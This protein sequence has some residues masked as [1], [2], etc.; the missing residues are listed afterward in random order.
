MIKDIKYSGHTA[1]PSDYECPDGS[2][3]LSLNLIP[4]DGTMRP[5]FPQFM[6]LRM[7]DGERALFIHKPDGARNLLSIRDCAEGSSLYWCPIGNGQ[8]DTSD[9]EYIENVTSTINGVTSVG[10][11]VMIATSDGIRYYIWREHSYMSLGNRP[12]FV[13]IEF[14]CQKAKTGLENRT[15]GYDKELFSGSSNRAPSKEDV[16]KLSTAI[17]GAL[18]SSAA[19]SA[20]KKGCF[21]Q[22][23]FVRYAFRLFD[24][25]YAWHSA[26]VLMLPVAI[27]PI[28]RLGQVRKDDE[29]VIDLSGNGRFVLMGRILPFD[30]ET[31]AKWKDIVSAVEIFV[32]AP[33]YT[34]D[35]AGEIENYRTV[36]FP[37]YIKSNN[38]AFFRGSYPA[39]TP[40]RYE[41]DMEDGI[42]E[43]GEGGEIGRTGIRPISE[44]AAK[45][46]DDYHILTGS[47]ANVL[48][49]PYYKDEDFGR[50]GQPTFL[51]RFFDLSGNGGGNVYEIPVM[52]KFLE[53]VRGCNL[54]YK[55]SEIQFDDIVLS[56]DFV[57]VKPYDN[58]LSSLVAR[59]TLPDDN[60]SHSLLIPTAVS[61]YNA[62][63]NMANMRI[64]PPAPLP[65]RTCIPANSN[66]VG[67]EGKPSLVKVTIW[68]MTQGVKLY[69][70]NGSDCESQRIFN[71]AK[72][73]PRYIFH[74]D[75]TAY[76]MK[77]EIDGGP[78]HIIPLKPHD[79]LN[80]AYF[81]SSHALLSPESVSDESL[82]N[83]SY[84]AESKIHSSEANNPFYIP[85]TGVTTVGNGAVLGLS[86]ATKALSQGQFGQFP[87]YAFTTEGV[88][89]MEVSSTGAFTARQPVTRDVCVSPQS[90]TQTDDSVLFATRRGVMMLSGSV[91]TSITDIIGTETPFRFDSLPSS[92]KLMELSGFTAGETSLLPFGEFLKD[93][94][95]VYDYANQR[96]HLF[97]PACDYGYVFSLKPKGWGMACCDTAYA[98]NSYPDAMAVDRKGRIVNFSTPDM[99]GYV[100]ALLVT[101]PIKLEVPDVL[102][103]IDTVIQR[104]YFRKGSVRCVLY[105]SRDLYNWH[106]VWSSKD[107]YLR[108][109]RGT[110]YKYFRIVLLADLSPDES[111]FGASIQFA[112]RLTD[113]PR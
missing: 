106:L 60:S 79:F 75:S 5:L 111:I 94:A 86:A 83:A 26:P 4:E 70:F 20:T 17:M 96:V 64:K 103:T 37:Y 22:P 41:E 8:K 80:G 10:N 97:N 2:L 69:S 109:F 21:Y 28:V 6:E 104:G 110:P 55:F 18:L 49:G 47:Y 63:F 53:H 31:F 108:G 12:P 102:K 68:S 84:V 76:K 82:T 52:D 42:D 92:G 46:A 90:I 44:T 45:E 3:A 36:S 38:G 30:R 7:A 40:S 88:W 11:I 61:A 59:P 65:I 1:V 25:S 101:R 33:L 48:P 27:P 32:S 14:G 105:G 58:D 72:I 39:R 95:M 51:D 35:Q 62:R 100:P 23:F 87:L 54:F 13:P 78:T 89:A 57:Y 66:A 73:C 77:I 9:A 98:I 43:T 24:G 29:A 74:P 50:R 67:Y 85:P 56:E 112:P 15:I 34:F 71:L 93:A 113:Q 16:K 99:T 81:L 107:H 91:A 19:E